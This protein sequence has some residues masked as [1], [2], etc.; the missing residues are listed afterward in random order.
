MSNKLKKN[1]KNTSEKEI[2]YLCFLEKKNIVKIHKVDHKHLRE[3]H[4]AYGFRSRKSYLYFS[5]KFQ[6]LIELI[7]PNCTNFE[8]FFEEHF[9]K[10][11]STSIKLLSSQS[12][13]IDFARGIGTG[14]SSAI[15]YDLCTSSSEEELVKKIVDIV[16][17]IE[18][19]KQNN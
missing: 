14:L 16:K 11:N 18:K 2:C 13:L 4:S 17:Q 1:Y 5:R 10:N 15:I 6:D 19:E 9:K 8:M 7:S 12:K 3:N